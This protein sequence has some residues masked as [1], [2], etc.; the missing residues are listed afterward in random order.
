MT[1][2]Y[3]IEYFNRGTT[4]LESIWTGNIAALAGSGTVCPQRFPQLTFGTLIVLEKT[5]G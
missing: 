1:H 4:R 3:L 2:V 5:L